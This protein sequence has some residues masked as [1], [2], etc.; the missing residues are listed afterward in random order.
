M[1]FIS[2]RNILSEYILNI[3]MVLTHD[4]ADDDDDD[5]DDHD[6]DDEDDDDD[7]DDD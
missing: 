4:D 3:S 5:D 7:D 6:H 2:G 1:T